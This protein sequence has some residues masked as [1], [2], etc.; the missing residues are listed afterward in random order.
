MVERQ[1]AAIPRSATTAL[2]RSRSSSPREEGFCPPRMV[3]KKIMRIF[4]FTSPKYCHLMMPFSYLFNQFWSE[5]QPVVVVGVPELP[6]NLPENFTISEFGAN[7]PADRW[8]DGAREFLETVDDEWFILMLEDY[9]ITRPVD[10]NGVTELGNFACVFQN[11]VRMDL[12][13][14]ILHGYGDCRNAIDICSWG[15]YDIIEKRIDSSYRMSLQAGMF[16]RKYFLKLCEETKSPWQLEM[17]NELQNDNSKRVLGCRQWP[18]RY[19]NAVDK[20]KINW[21][22]IRKIPAEHRREIEKWIQEI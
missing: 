22:Q 16:D 14:D 7:V 13:T 17:H 5:L 1:T 18:L 21:E 9:F 3:N 2:L 6:F 8:T 11:C 4:V 15:H 20:G 10:T 12:T 19:A